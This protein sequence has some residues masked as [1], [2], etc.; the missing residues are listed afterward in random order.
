MCLY[1][2]SLSLVCIKIHIIVHI[3]M[4]VFDNN[5]HMHWAA[6]LNGMT[7]TLNVFYSHVPSDFL[8]ALTATYL[9][10]FVFLVHR[11]STVL[12]W[13]SMR[14]WR[15]KQS[16]VLVIV[17]LLRLHHSSKGFCSHL[18]RSIG[19]NVVVLGLWIV[20]AFQHHRFDTQTWRSNGWIIS[21]FW[22][23]LCGPLRKEQ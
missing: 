1:L 4:I 9:F 2:L 17:R 3:L 19:C 13:F 15:C 22:W 12:V 16:W 20:A 8:T 23:R 6:F 18:Y 5:Q 21:F 11:L 7:L 10:S 14:A